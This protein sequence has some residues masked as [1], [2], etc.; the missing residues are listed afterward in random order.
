MRKTASQLKIAKCKLQNANCKM[1]VAN[2]S[3]HTGN[4]SPFFIFHFS[5]FILQ[6]AVAVLLVFP[7][8]VLAATS[9]ADEAAP[10]A[11]R[12]AREIYVPFSD[13][14]VLLERQPKRVLLG[15]AEYDDLVKK[16]KRTPETHAPLPAAVIAADY[17]VTLGQENAE[18]HGLLTIE[19]LERGLHALPLD[20]GGVGLADAKL[21]GRDAPLGRDDAGQLV[22]F[23]EGLGRHELTLDMVAR[24]DTTA[25]R[26]VLS[27][28]LPRPPA[29]KL[30]LTA[31]G[32]VEIKEGADVVSRVVGQVSN[33][34]HGTDVGQVANLS[35][36]ET[37]TRFEL[38]P[39]QGDTTLV[40]TLNSH[41]QQHEGLV[42]ARSVVV[43]EVTA[44]YEKL[45]ATVSLQILHR[46]ADQFRFVVPDGFEIT[47]VA[48]PLLAYW[49][50]RQEG[51][52]RL[53]GVKL[54]EQTTDTVV[55]RIAA[56]RAPARLAGW[57]APRLEPLDVVGSV[58]VLGLLVEDRLN[59]ESF[60]TE[61]LIPVD[62]SVLGKAWGRA[63]Q[64]RPVAAWYAPQGNYALTAHYVKPP[65]GLAVNANLVLIL[66]D[67]G[68]K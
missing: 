50:V 64:L 37:T 3:R 45:H 55:L 65:A 63:P 19:V 30:R 25:A 27:Y 8:G 7:L 9:F 20:L 28:R 67:K 38:L 5:F 56:I 51:G 29:A 54:R 4:S 61:G 57:H 59:V 24:L 44:A 22:L 12:A 26:Q 40:M 33:L 66:S 47:D 41:F 36:P 34:S 21:D 6:S 15:R 23:V 68:Q 18:I 49:D 31:P 1:Q 14:H 11:E 52:R 58:T 32:D 10:P 46:A 35:H 62:V 42:M 53:L 13:L 48:S 39:R 60:Q 2:C 17:G 43:E 16:A